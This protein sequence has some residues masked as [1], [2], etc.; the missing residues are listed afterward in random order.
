[1]EQWLTIG[2]KTVQEL[3]EH[4]P[5]YKKM[6]A[7]LAEAEE[8]YLKVREKLSPEDQEIIEHYIALCEDVEYQ[9]THTAFRVGKMLR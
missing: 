7:E 1:M 6:M 5:E 2:A 8:K 3:L 4:D 9:K